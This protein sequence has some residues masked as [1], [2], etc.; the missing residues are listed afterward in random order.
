MTT[1]NIFSDLPDHTTTKN[2][3]IWM[4]HSHAHLVEFATDPVTT[5]VISNSLSQHSPEDGTQQ[6]AEYYRKLR[7]IILNFH[8]VLLFGPTSAK[9]ELLNLCRADHKFSHVRIETRDSDKMT[10]NEQQAFVRDYFLER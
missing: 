3:G 7:D 5:H 6:L 2:L 10:Q 9:V 8:H 4:D 1:T